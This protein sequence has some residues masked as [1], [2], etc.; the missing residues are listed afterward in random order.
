MFENL[1]ITLTINQI[2]PKRAIPRLEHQR[3]QKIF[4][5]GLP[6]S[7]T[8]ETLKIFFSQYGKV[9]DATVMV[10]RESNRSKG[11][12]FVTF[13]D[14]PAV[15]NL[16]QIHNLELEGKMVT[17]PSCVLCDCDN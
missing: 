11:F 4:V 15:D 12:G 17:S 6:G 7:A 8:N 5:G 13:E 2:D 3:T 1:I 9:V 10:D 14:Q 16:V